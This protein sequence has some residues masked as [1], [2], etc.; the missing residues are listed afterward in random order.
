[1]REHHWGNIR[2]RRGRKIIEK[3]KTGWQINASRKEGEEGK[4]KKEGRV[5]IAREQ[6]RSG[7]RPIM[8]SRKSK[9]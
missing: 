2:I 4:T 5:L 7:P 6:P 8:R 9:I 3:K 1:L